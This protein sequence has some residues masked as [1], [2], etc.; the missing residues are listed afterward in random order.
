MIPEDLLS[1]N[2]SPGV[3][4]YPGGVVGMGNVL[5]YTPTLTDIMNMPVLSTP[6]SDLHWECY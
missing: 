2:P 5:V 6:G 1:L 3:Y 4:Y